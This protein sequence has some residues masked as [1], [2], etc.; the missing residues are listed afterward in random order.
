M[1]M[2]IGKRLR[3]AAKKLISWAESSEQ[4]VQ[5]D[6]IA[7]PVRRLTPSSSLAVSHLPLTTAI[8]LLQALVH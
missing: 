8:P 7:P 1:D 2:G 3:N 6:Y 5:R 4:E